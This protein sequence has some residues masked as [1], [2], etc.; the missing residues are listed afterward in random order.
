M[1]FLVPTN[2]RQLPPVFEMAQPF[3][4]DAI[5]EVAYDTDP[6]AWARNHILAILLTSPGERVMRP[7]YGAGIF[8]F[9]WENDDQLVQAQIIN[10]I[11]QAVAVSE[12]NI[13]LQTVAFVPQPDFSGVV[14]LD[15]AFSVGASPTSYY[16][17]LGRSWH[18]DNGMSIAPVSLGT[19]SDVVPTGINVPPIDYTSRD[20]A[21]LVNDLLTLIPFLPTGVD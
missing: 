15:I 3:N 7:G 20:Y 12:P 14:T 1:T 17:Q 8:N 16:D 10:N 19:I 2:F 13:L 9:V 4:I 21:S 5:G 6:A 18:R 11:R